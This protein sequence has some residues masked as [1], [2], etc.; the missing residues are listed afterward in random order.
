MFNDLLFRRKQGESAEANSTHR[1]VRFSVKSN[2]ASYPLSYMSVEKTPEGLDLHLAM[3]PR[4][5][6]LANE[7]RRFQSRK[8][9]LPFRN[10]EERDR[11][12][13]FDTVSRVP[14]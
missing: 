9:R 10:L 4:A 11:I 14:R 13:T 1:L 3:I 6:A 7:K 12:R 2:P 8:R 5:F